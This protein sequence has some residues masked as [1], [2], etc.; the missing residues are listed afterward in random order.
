[1]GHIMTKDKTTVL[2]HDVTKGYISSL[3][4]HF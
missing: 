2:F 3:S 1:M 4:S